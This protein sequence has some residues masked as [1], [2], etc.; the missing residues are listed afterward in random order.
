MADTDIKPLVSPWVPEQ[1]V[2]KQKVLGKGVEEAGEYTSAVARCFIQGINESEPTT[3]KP[4][5]RWLEEELADVVATSQ[6]LV[7]TFDLDVDFIR[8]RAEKKHAQ[9][10]TW[11]STEVVRITGTAASYKAVLHEAPYMM[12]P[13]AAAVYQK[14]KPCSLGVG[15]DEYG[16]CYADAHGEPDR[17]PR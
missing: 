5:K 1:D 12:T 14:S 16:V 10:A 11:F 4:N 8:Q 9:L 3:G 15:C 7:E 13:E 2:R 17:C 6:H